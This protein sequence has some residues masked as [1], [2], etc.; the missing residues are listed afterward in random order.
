[1]GNWATNI[2]ADPMFIDLNT[3]DLHLQPNSPA[4][5]AGVDDGTRVDLDGIAR[6]QGD[7]FDIGAFEVLV[8]N[9]QP[10]EIP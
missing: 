5:D 6:P 4:I 3:P 2:T 9:N 10:K 7:G 1:M 8:L